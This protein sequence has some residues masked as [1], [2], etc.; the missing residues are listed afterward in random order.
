MLGGKA[1]WV[2]GGW[3]ERARRHTVVRLLDSGGARNGESTQ[4]VLS[5]DSGHSSN[6]LG[7]SDEE[8][9]YVNDLSVLLWWCS[10]LGSL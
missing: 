10:S 3:K 6:W 7:G 8:R 5:S 2:K 4:L 9:H 1:R